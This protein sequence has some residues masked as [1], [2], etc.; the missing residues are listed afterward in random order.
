MIARIASAAAFA[1][2]LA[3]SSAQAQNVRLEG[4]IVSADATTLVVKTNK[5]EEAKVNL[6]DKMPV[7][8]VVKKTVA[9]IKPGAFIGVGAIP[10]ADGSQKAV[11]IN[12][13]A[14]PNNEGHR[15]WDGVPQGTMTNATVDTS[16]SSVEGQV[17]MVKYKDGE[18]KII[19]E[20]NTNII[21]SVNG[22]KN[23]LKPGAKVAIA[24]AVKG[25][26]GN[27]D[28]PKINVGRDGVVP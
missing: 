27:Y 8:A 9:D 6:S 7:S 18:K 23:D 2:A 15:P 24:N 11:R 12:I 14:A 13:F 5:G 10:Q 17:V 19:I 20:P 16:V 22:D 25:A 3:F 4:T 28:A 1:T 21:T 26:N